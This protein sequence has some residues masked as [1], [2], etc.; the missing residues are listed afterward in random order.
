[1][2][3]RVDNGV[4]LLQAIDAWNQGDLPK[5][6]ELYDADIVLHGAPPGMRGVRAMYT[7]M[8]RAYPGSQ[9]RVDDLL[10]ADERVACRYTW[11]A[12]ARLTGESVTM[13]GMTILHF[14]DGRCVER[15][16]FEG[17]PD[18]PA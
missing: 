1:M 3:E 9:L 8:W 13:P 4:V 18:T 16:D 2:P 17:S 15:W 14:R 10:V 7:G 11:T 6:L 5:Y 12:V